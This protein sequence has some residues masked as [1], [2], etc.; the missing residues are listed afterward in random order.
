MNIVVFGIYDTAVG[1][2]ALS[3]SK[4]LE[5]PYIDAGREFSKFLLLNEKLLIEN[6]GEADLEKVEKIFI[7]QIAKSNGFIFL[8]HSMFI[9]NKNYL[10]FKDFLKLHLNFCPKDEVLEELDKLL[11]AL[12]DISISLDEIE[13]DEVLEKIKKFSK[14]V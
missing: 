10:Y 8:P 2:S 4:K 13:N 5:V 1:V 6:K 9:S 7:K 14:K 3:L 11:T 12:A